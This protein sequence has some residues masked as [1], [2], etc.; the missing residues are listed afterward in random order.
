MYLLKLFIFFHNGV[1]WASDTIT[2]VVVK[3]MCVNVA[4]WILK[5]IIAL[6]MMKVV[7]CDGELYIVEGRGI[8]L[9]LKYKF[10]QTVYLHLHVLCKSRIQLVIIKLERGLILI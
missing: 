8:K 5:T 6:K 9:P 2:K 4:D 1:Q 10:A 3:E 7:L